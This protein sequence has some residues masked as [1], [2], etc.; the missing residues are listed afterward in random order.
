MTSSYVDPGNDPSGTP[1]SSICAHSLGGAPDRIRQAGVGHRHRAALQ[2]EDRVAE[3][4]VVL[5]ELPLV[6]DRVDR[7]EHAG[8]ARALGQVAP[9]E[10]APA[11]QLRRERA[12][13]RR[14]HALA[15]HVAERDDQRVRLGRQ[16]VVEVAAE[17]AR[18]RER[19]RDLDTLQPLGQLGRQQRRSARAARSALP[20][21]AAL[22]WRAALRTAARSRSPPPPGWRAASGSRRRAW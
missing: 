7:R 15:R 18:R 14:R 16:K 8:G 22:R 20:S 13:E 19:G 6:Q 5:L 2:I 4:A 12:V 1:G 11:H 10:G 3:R 21:R 9:P 17:L